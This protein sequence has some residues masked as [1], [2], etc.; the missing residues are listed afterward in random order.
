MGDIAKDL[1]ELRKLSKKIEEALEKTAIQRIEIRK[2]A[3]ITAGK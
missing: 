3:I 2:N 1:E